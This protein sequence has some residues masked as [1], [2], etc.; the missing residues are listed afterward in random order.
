M[1]KKSILVA[2]VGFFVLFH[3]GAYAQSNL[4]EAL[5]GLAQPVAEKYTNPVITGLS[6]NLNTGWFHR[7]PKAKKFGLDLEAG[8]VFTG[9]LF[10][11]KDQSF[12]HTGAFALSQQ[13]A[14][15][16]ATNYLN[17][18]NPSWYN[19]LSHTQKQQAIDS[20]AA[21][22][23]RQSQ[24][25]PF[26]LTVSGA[27]FIGKRKNKIVVKMSSNNFTFTDPNG[28]TQTV[29]ISGTQDTLGIGGVTGAPVIPLAAPQLTVGT[30][31][32]TQLTLR[33]LPP[34]GISKSMG[35]MNYL[36][37]GVQHNPG[38]WFNS[39]I[40]LD[41][42][43]AFYQQNITQGKLFEAH[44]MAYGI[45]VSKQIGF[46]FLNLTPYA[47]YLRE[48]SKMKFTYTYR[49][50]PVN[51]IDVAFKAKGQN[52]DRITV[53]TNFKILLININADYS[54]AKKPAYSAGV[55]FAI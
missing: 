47:G 22:I 30:I 39:P 3:H 7:S 25:N 49:L 33:Y 23:Y 15:G 20:L 29:T 21:K 8:V 43:F 2:I 1:K 28:N 9:T 34:V 38:V 36:G 18:S 35:K 55:N 19:A 46:G 48:S 14:S 42:A 52:K 13:T 12:T 54:I 32:G 50:D 51:S 11:K 16:I 10:T 5:T 53:G 37:W 4:K 27:T 44:A 40:P 45:T 31:M 41:I 26:D 17:T 24:I 6:S